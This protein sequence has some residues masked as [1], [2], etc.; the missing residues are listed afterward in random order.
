MTN[1]IFSNN[2]ACPLTLVYKSRVLAIR[3][4]YR[5][6]LA[7]AFIKDVSVDCVQS[8][9]SDV[10][11]DSVEDEAKVFNGFFTTIDVMASSN[12]E[13]VIDFGL[14]LVKEFRGFFESDCWHL[15]LETIITN[16]FDKLI[17]IL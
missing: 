3:I 15:H 14:H 11:H 17:V 6:V 1:P 9:T 2:L 7:V 5:L 10:G 16:F 12:A 4:I 13:K 8:R